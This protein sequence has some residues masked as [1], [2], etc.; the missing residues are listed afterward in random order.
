MFHRI[1]PVLTAVLFLFVIS[2]QLVAQQLVPGQQ[3]AA[4]SRVFSPENGIEFTVPQ[5][6]LGGIPAGSAAF[7][8]GSNT[9]AGV[10]IIIM[11]TSSSVS[12]LES[13]LSEAQDMGEGVVLYPSSNPGG[14]GNSRSNEFTNGYY[15]GYA[16]GRVA[17]AGNGLVVFFAGPQEMSGEYKQLAET[18]LQSVKFSAPQVSGQLQQVKQALAGMMLKRMSSYYSGGVDGAYIG[19]SSQQTLHL[20]RDG[21]YAYSSSS[22]VGGGSS[23]GGVSGYGSGGNEDSGQWDVEIMGAQIALVLRSNSGGQSMH[24]LE[25]RGEETYLDDERAYRVPSERCP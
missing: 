7:L 22:N 8:L 1:Y 5:D 19:G 15:Y 14:S 4:G 18:I 9:K 11:R 23:G 25:F 17:G 10:G 2:T 13:L 24:K 3:Y 21:S 16:T 20:C 6:W 12:E